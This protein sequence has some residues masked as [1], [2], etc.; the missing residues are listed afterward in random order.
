MVTVYY[1]ADF[2]IDKQPPHTR[3]FIRELGGSS[4]NLP[5]HMV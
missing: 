1:V 4:C 5:P 3:D 2:F